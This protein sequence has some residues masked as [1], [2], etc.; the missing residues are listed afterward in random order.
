MLID[1][2]NITLSTWINDLQHYRYEALTARPDPQG[3]SLGQV[4]M[5]LIEETRFYMEQME[6]CMKYNDNG[7]EEMDERG[8]VMFANNS[9]PY[10]R[11]K[12]DPFISENVQQ[13]ASKL[14]LHEDMLQLKRQI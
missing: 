9:F 6:S 2:L 8:K 14:Q 12:G 5:H 4:Y 10:Q 3:W 11:I 1:D 13:P 7:H